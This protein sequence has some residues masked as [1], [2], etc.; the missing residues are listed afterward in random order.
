MKARAFERY[1]ISL[2][3]LMVQ[4]EFAEGA[5]VSEIVNPWAG[6]SRRISA[7]WR[8]LQ[9]TRTA[10]L[11]LAADRVPCVGPA[12]QPPATAR[13]VASRYCRQRARGRLKRNPLARPEA[14]ALFA[15]H[16]DS[17]ALKSQV[18]E[19]VYNRGH[20]DAYDDA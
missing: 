3:G 6:T 4:P 20:D 17:H 13:R 12:A 9:P 18:R 8:R 1:V 7:A 11:A 15:V 10:E 16:I 2:L 14:G 5:M 19:Q